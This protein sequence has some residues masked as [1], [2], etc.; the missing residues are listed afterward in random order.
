MQIGD[1]ASD[2]QVSLAGL[3]A[4]RIA[5]GELEGLRHLAFANFRPQ[6]AIHY[7]ET[8]K[9]IRDDAGASHFD[10]AKC[11][12]VIHFVPAPEGEQAQ[13]QASATPSSPPRAGNDPSA[14]PRR[15]YDTSSP[16]SRG[17]DQGRRR[18]RP[19]G[20]VRAE[21]HSA[22]S[23]PPPMREER[24]DYEEALTQMLE[25]LQR[26]ER[27]RRFVGI[28]WF[29]DRF[30][31]EQN[32]SWSNDPRTCGAM[33]RIGTED[34]LVVTHQVTNPKN[35]QHPV[36]AIRLNRNHPRCQDMGQP[37]EQPRFKPVRIRGDVLSSTV[38]G[39]RR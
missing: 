1:I 23:P 26:A 38:V 33:L 29:R 19:Q 10:P 8:H 36:T 6:V 32:F 22:T 24:I 7:A 15:G 13:Q 18:P 3:D 27:E 11:E 16:P 2:L 4:T 17:Y 34:E 14:T 12:V 31:P 28:K 5:E 35:P 25:A 39:Q 21:N 20:Y 9:K 30:L 37:S